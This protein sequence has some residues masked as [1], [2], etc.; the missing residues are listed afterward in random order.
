MVDRS[1]L[2]QPSSQVIVAIYQAKGRR[3]LKPL[4]LTRQP[5]RRAT[6]H[7]P[8]AS[9]S[10]LLYVARRH[11]RLFLCTPAHRRPHKILNPPAARVLSRFCTSGSDVC[12]PFP[13]Y[14]PTSE[15]TKFLHEPNL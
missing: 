10:H 3:D 13:P 14:E 6:D 7:H 4:P 11:R 12:R 8:I 1:L 5:S 15:C 2:A 9:D